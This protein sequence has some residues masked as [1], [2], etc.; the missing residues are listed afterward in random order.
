MNLLK[1]KMHRNGCTAGDLS[2]LS[3]I[4]EADITAMA[5]QKRA[6]TGVLCDV[7]LSLIP[8]KDQKPTPYIMWKDYVKNPR[9]ERERILGLYC[10]AA[11]KLLPGRLVRRFK[12]GNIT[13]HEIARIE[14]A[15]EAVNIATTAG[16]TEREKRQILEACKPYKLIESRLEQYLDGS[17]IPERHIIKYIKLIKEQR[18]V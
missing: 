3:G 16:L 2:S 18:N 5:A 1:E 17:I 12:S 11:L 13:K 9:A 4:P 15:A 14:G 6:P 8:V 10:D 7:L